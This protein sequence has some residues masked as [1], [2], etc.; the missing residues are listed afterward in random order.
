M[1]NSPKLLKQ[2]QKTRLPQEGEGCDIEDATQRAHP[3]LNNIAR[4]S[5]QQHASREKRKQGGELV[6]LM[7]AYEQFKA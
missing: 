3:D 6:S 2:S 5:R 7:T 4:L 1:Q